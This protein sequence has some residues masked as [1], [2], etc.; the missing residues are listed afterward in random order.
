MKPIHLSFNDAMMQYGSDKPD[1]RY[2]FEINNLSKD[3][4]NIS[5]IPFFNNINNED[6]M[7]Y[8][9]IDNLLSFISKTKIKELIHDLKNTT[10]IYVIDNKIT[11]SIEK[12]LNENDQKHIISQLKLNNGDVLFISFGKKYEP[13]ISLG[14]ISI[15]FFI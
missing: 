7:K 1:L 4:F 9:K 2:K 10:F 6:V 3:I 11:G 8:I 12:Y 14:N 15:L 13:S 5:K